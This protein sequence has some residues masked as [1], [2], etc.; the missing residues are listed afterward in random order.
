M[1]VAALRWLVAIR[2]TRMK[3]G[4]TVYRG[5]KFTIVSQAAGGFAIRIQPV[6]G[7]EILTTFTFA[8]VDD[9]ITSAR[10]IVD[11]KCRG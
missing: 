2:K 4:E 9:A 5:Y 3:G 6:G 7:G 10:T 8:I 1:E 11:W